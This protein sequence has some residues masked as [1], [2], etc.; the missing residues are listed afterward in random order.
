[1]LKDDNPCIRTLSLSILENIYEKDKLE[2]YTSEET[3]EIILL[4]INC[5]DKN[6]VELL[7]RYLRKLFKRDAAK[8]MRNLKI[9]QKKHFNLFMAYELFNIN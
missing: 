6:F 2:Y 5:S 7:K 8:V 9:L 1:M 3:L 4:S